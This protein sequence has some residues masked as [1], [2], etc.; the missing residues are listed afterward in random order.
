[1]FV[2]WLNLFPLTLVSDGNIECKALK[3]EGKASNF[4]HFFSLFLNS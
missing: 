1:M 4:D 3:H 2:C